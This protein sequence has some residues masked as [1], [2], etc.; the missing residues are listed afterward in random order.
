[1]AIMI[2]YVV[3]AI[4]GEWFPVFGLIQLYKSVITSENKQTKMQHF[5]FSRYI[6]GGEHSVEKKSLKTQSED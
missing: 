2:S 4:I 3:F 1:L 5:F 6:Q